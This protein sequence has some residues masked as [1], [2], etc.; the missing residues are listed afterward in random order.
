M[1]QAVD[2]I[3]QLNASQRRAVE[4][5]CGPLLVVAGA[6]SGKTRALTFR[7]ANLVLTHRVDPEHI[8]AVTFTNK[9]A[10][11]MKERI[12]KLF[13]DQEAQAK[14]GKPL[15]ALPASDQMRLK[16]KVYKEITKELW[17]GTFHALCGRILRFDIEKYRSSQGY[18]WNRNFSI[19][20][21]SDT[22]SLVKNIVVNQLNLDDKK[23]EP[24]SVRYAI[25]NA[26]NQG[27]TPE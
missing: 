8:L 3:A 23:F 4:H 2:F 22:Q 20:D 18:Q 27:L 15:S 5:Y 9:A 26:K 6:G 19:F 24:R 7:I 17:I 1:P 25:S 11:E 16:S 12:E 10:R 14:F 21:E 13:A